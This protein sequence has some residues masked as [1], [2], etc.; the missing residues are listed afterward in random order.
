MKAK[1]ATIRIE[2]E[3]WEQFKQEARKQGRTASDVIID[4]VQQ[5][6][7]NS[8]GKPPKPVAIGL[9]T[10]DEIREIVNHELDKR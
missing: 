6:V 1:T 7:E 9:F 8:Q 4:F 5:F 3:L 2:P 10:E